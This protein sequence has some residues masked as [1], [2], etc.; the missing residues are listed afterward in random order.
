MDLCRRGRALFWAGAIT[1]M[2]EA[3]SSRVEVKVSGGRRQ[4]SVLQR[5]LEMSTKGGYDGSWAGP[6]SQPTPFRS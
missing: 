5:P 2:S 6:Q 1:S 3:H 4:L